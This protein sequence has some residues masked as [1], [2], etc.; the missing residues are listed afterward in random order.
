MAN[1][2]KFV[3]TKETLLPPICAKC[4]SDKVVRV[5]QTIVWLNPLFYLTILLGGIPFFVVYLV[6]RKKMKLSVP[7]C[8]H[9]RRLIQTLRI[10]TAVF[11]IGCPATG[12]FLLEY[13]PN[14]EGYWFLIPAFMII[15]AF[16]TLRFQRPL[17]AVE[18]DKDHA[19]LKGACEV[20]L[21]RI[22]SPETQGTV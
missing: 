18:I 3:V 7:L 21:S 17:T 22:E 10:F 4:G 13:A 6:A 8:E 9:H 19:T 14:S 12:L 15:G 2:L 11:L 16:I 5:D 20:F 1:K